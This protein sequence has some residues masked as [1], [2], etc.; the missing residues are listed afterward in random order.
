MPATPEDTE[1]GRLSD[2]ALP[3]AP[4]ERAPG[5]KT[6]RA[7]SALIRQNEP[8]G[9]NATLQRTR[10]RRGI[11]CRKVFVADPNGKVGDERAP[12]QRHD[13]FCL[14]SCIQ[15]RHEERRGPHSASHP[16]ALAKP[17]PPSD[18]RTVN[19][20]LRPRRAAVGGQRPVARRGIGRARHPGSQYALARGSSSHP[21]V[22]RSASDRQP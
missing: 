1:S 21:T 14:G 15:V 6:R 13:G 10:L 22:P 20:G 16:G 9:S 8:R 2:S 5:A 4:S 19:L 18:P 7:T 11:A 17:R 3:A 12:L